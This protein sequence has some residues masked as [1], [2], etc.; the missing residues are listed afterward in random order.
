MITF[1]HQNGNGQAE[2]VSDASIKFSVTGDDFLLLRLQLE[3][4]KGIP[5]LNHFRQ[6][7]IPGKMKRYKK[8]EDVEDLLVLLKLVQDRYPQFKI[9]FEDREP[10]QPRYTLLKW[11]GEYGNEAKFVVRDNLKN[12]QSLFTP[13]RCQD[14]FW[15]HSDLARDKAVSTWGEFGEESFDDLEPIAF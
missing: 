6:Q 1:F 7:G 4:S 9:F 11:N 2:I 3:F 8:V 10:I 12:T 5:T 15:F 13:G 14:L